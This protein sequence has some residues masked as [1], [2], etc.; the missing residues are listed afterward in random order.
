MC[1]YLVSFHTYNQI[2]VK[3]REIYIL[4]LYSTPLYG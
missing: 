2:L 4:Y 1:P 3:N